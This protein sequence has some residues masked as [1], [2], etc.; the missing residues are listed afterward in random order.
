LKQDISNL[1]HTLAQKNK[2]VSDQSEQLNSVISSQLHT[3]NSSHIIKYLFKQGLGHRHNNYLYEKLQHNQIQYL[4]SASRLLT[5]QQQILTSLSSKLLN[6]EEKEK[7]LVKQININKSLEQK[8]HTLIAQANANLNNNNTKLST[9][10]KDEEQLS[11]KL[12]DLHRSTKRYLKD[13]FKGSLIPPVSL[14][15]STFQIKPPIIKVQANSPVFAVFTGKVVFADW[16]KGFGLLIIIDHG[17]SY[18]SLYGHNQTLLKKPNQQVKQG[19]VI[20]LVG[21]SGGQS[22]ASLFFEIR[23][24]GQQITNLNRWFK[25]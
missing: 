11:S 15:P 16:L 5:E 12:K 1:S 6:Q 4:L 3:L 14:S 24:D 25:L 20:S 8:K 19:E 7:S 9:L 10:V 21:N 18:M 17:N 13:N 2:L 23:K 22:E